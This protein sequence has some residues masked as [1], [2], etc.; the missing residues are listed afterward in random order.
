MA[1]TLGMGECSPISCQRLKG[2]YVT[3]KKPLSI[4]SGT[5]VYQAGYYAE[6]PLAREEE[7]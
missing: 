5:S 6:Y 7:V 2:V 1:G 4:P 3:L